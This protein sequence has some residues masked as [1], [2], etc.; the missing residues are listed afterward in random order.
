M[1]L[2][3]GEFE[4]EPLTGPDDEPTSAERAELL[5]LAHLDDYLTADSVTFTGDNDDEIV[6]WMDLHCGSVDK[7]PHVADHG[8]WLTFH[9]DG[10]RVTVGIGDRVIVGARGWFEVA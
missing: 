1:S 10:R 5:T 3:P 2:L 9:A 7:L 6:A 8:D 4:V